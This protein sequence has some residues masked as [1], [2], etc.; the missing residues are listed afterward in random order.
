MTRFVSVVFPRLV[1]APLAT[2]D[3]PITSTASARMRPSRSFRP[4]T[5][6]CDLLC[7]TAVPVVLDTEPIADPVAN[8]FLSVVPPGTL[9]VVPAELRNLDVPPRSASHPRLRMPIWPVLNVGAIDHDAAYT[10][11]SSAWDALLS[12]VIAL[13]MT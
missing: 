1:A 9:T 3:R 13:P 10:L 5:V 8:R 2:S 11:P 4:W 12:D 6:S 7:A